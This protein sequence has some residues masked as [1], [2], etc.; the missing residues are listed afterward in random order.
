MD[1]RPTI[2][3]HTDE[4]PDLMVRQDSGGTIVFSV[5][6]GEMSKVHV[7][8]PPEHALAFYRQLHNATN[9]CLDIDIARSQ[10]ASAKVIGS[11]NGDC[12]CQSKGVSHARSTD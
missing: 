7:F 11:G 3:L 8:I 4:A 1:V 6:F 5:K 9:A 12:G 10:A 2:L